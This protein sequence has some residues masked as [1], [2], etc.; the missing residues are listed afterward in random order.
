MDFKFQPT[1]HNT[2]S[3]SRYFLLMIC[4]AQPSWLSAQLLQRV[5]IPLSQPYGVFAT[6]TSIHNGNSVKA[7]FANSGLI[8]AVRPGIPPS[9]WPVEENT[10]MPDINVVVGIEGIFRDTLQ[11]FTISPDTVRGTRRRDGRTVGV[12][13]RDTVGRFLL[14]GNLAMVVSDSDWYATSHVTIRAAQI[15]KSGGGEFWGMTPFDGFRNPLQDG[16]AMSQ[17]PNSWP[18]RWPDLPANQPI[19]PLS[20]LAQWN[21]YFGTGVFNADQ[22]SYFAV[23]DGADKWW[24]SRHNYRPY[25]G[26]TRRAGAGLVM[27]VRGLQFASFLA[28]DNIFW[29]YEITNESLNDYEKVFFGSIAGTDI[30]GAGTGG[31]DGVSAFDQRNGITY[32]FKSTVNNPPV[33]GTWNRNFYPPGFIGLSFLESPGNPYDGIDNDND[34]P[35]TT[36]TTRTP[37]RFNAS[38]G[39]GVYDYDPTS[40]VVD[41]VTGRLNYTFRRTLAAGDPIVLIEKR[42]TVILGRTVRKYNRLFRRVGTTNETVFSLEKRFVIGPGITLTEIANN[43]ADDNLNGVIDENYQLSVERQ[44][45]SYDLVNRSVRTEQ[46]IPLSYIPYISLAQEFPTG[47]PAGTGYYDPV[48]INRDLYPMIDERRD[49]AID[50]NNDLFIDAVDV[51]ESDQIGLTSFTFGDNNFFDMGNT[52]RMVQSARPGIFTIISDI[53]QTTDFDYMYGTGYFPLF[54]G[55]TERFSIAQVFGQDA[56][57]VVE[58]RNIVQAIYDANYNFTRPPN[59]PVLQSYTNDRRVTLFWDGTAEDFSDEFIRRR[60]NLPVGTNDPRVRSFEGYKIYKATDANFADILTITGSRGE[61]AQQRVALAQFD[62]VNNVQGRF[63]LTSAS[64]LEQSRGIA[65]FLG[66]NTGIQRTFT[67]SNVVNGKTYFYAVVAYTRGDSGLSIYPAE[68]PVIAQRDLR[69][70]LVLSPNIVVVTPGQKAAG[71]TVP[72]NNG[73]ATPVV[74]DGR[75]PAGSGRVVYTMIN[76]QAVKDA[77]YEIQFTDTATDS[78]DNNGNGRNESNDIFELLGRTAN[79]RVI[80]ITNPARPDTVIRKNRRR[81]DTASSYQPRNPTFFAGDD[82]VFNGVYL[83][84]TNFSDARYDSLNS[85]WVNNANVRTAVNTYQPLS[86]DSVRS[87]MFQLSSQFTVLPR[88][89]N[90]IFTIV[91]R[92]S[93]SSSEI[94]YTDANGNINVLDPRPSNFV[95][96]NASTGDTIR[97]FFGRFSSS[98]FLDT[99]SV[100]VGLVFGKRPPPPGVPDTLFTWRVSFNR[101]TVAP[102]QRVRPQVGDKF[103]LRFLTPFRQGDRFQMQTTASSFDPTR[104]KT[105]LDQIR[106]V[107]NPYMARSDYEQQLPLGVSQGRGDRR[108]RFTNI[109]RGATIRIYTVR[110]DLVQTLTQTESAV[111][112]NVFWNLRSRENLDVA[113]G[114]YLYHVDAPGVGTKTGKFLIIK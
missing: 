17:F 66:D 76:P 9:A 63:P 64:L 4:L 60:L 37:P 41:P 32:S 72:E 44:V 61:P 67:D 28:Q 113:Y 26:D 3:V 12:S 25:V 88:A 55:Q 50:N 48:F 57:S 36:R 21:G 47:Y 96:T 81:L 24:L 82:E 99:A 104:A 111:E 33:A 51:R 70:N 110:G 40:G 19:N 62:I 42:D 102:A 106:V 31:R 59:P 86:P 18:D 13:I 54:A 79:Y 30:G 107:P 5:S 84:M 92:G 45:V 73:L 58:N 46:L 15:S 109:P 90:F 98:T 91:P 38:G 78:I 8:G 75:G 65:Y 20:G 16:V 23:T 52:N 87:A 34:W 11:P 1:M 68:S 94:T 97:Y 35:Q 69:G 49:D 6:R 74:V 112:G 95:I 2:F 53:N 101:S 56:R 108:L 83:Q 71:Y 85:S 103:L 39:T 14:G 100:E 27:K 22:E 114:L 105:D 43:L 80:D 89:D 93:V 7:G 10:Y 29:L 77:T